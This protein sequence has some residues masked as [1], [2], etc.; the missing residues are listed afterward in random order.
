MKTKIILF[1]I[2]VTTFSAQAQL[3]NAG[4]IAF[5]G[6]NADA[7][8][9]IAFITFKDI[10]ANT[11]I[12]FC[13]SEW[14]GTSFGT[15][16]GDFTWSSGEETIPAGTIITINELSATIQPSVGTITVN[17][18]GGLSSSSDAIFAFVGTSPRTVSTMLAAISN[19]LTGFGD[20]SNS[21]LTLGSTAIVLPEGTDIAVYDEIKTGL[22]ANGYL[23]QLN[24]IS[25]WKVEDTANDDSANG[26]TPDLP[27]NTSIFELAI[28]DASAPT[29]ATVSVLTQNTIIITFSENVNTTATDITNYSFSPNITI[30]NAS[31]DVET[32][33]VT[34][35]HTGF[36]NGTAYQ[37][38]ISNIEDTSNNVLDSNYMSPN[39]FFNSLTTGLIFSEIMYNAP[40]ENSDQLEFLEIYN[41]SDETINLGGLKVKDSGNFIFEF[42]ESTVP[43]G[44]TVLLATDKESADAFYGVI[45][46]D[47]PQGISNALGNGGEN[48]QILNSQ[49]A[50]ISQVTY[51]DASP[52]A[53]SADGTGP[54]LELLNPNG[55]FNDGNNW[56]ASTNLVEISLD[57]K[58]YASPGVF[59]PVEAVN[60]SF[61]SE[62]LLVNYDDET[63]SITINLSN[64]SNNVVSVNLTLSP[65]ISNDANGLEY[66]FENQTITFPTNVTTQTITV[67]LLKNTSTNSDFYFTLELTNPSGGNLGGITQKIIYVVGKEKDVPT[68]SNVLDINHVSSY[69]VDASGS[70]EIVA[71]DPISQHLFVMNSTAKKVEILDFS[72]PLAISPIKTIDLSS[73]GIGGTSVAVKNGIIAAT[74]E[75]ENFQNGK[76]IFMDVYGTILSAIEVGVLP[77]MV[78]FTPDGTKVITANEGQPSDDYTIDPEGS[79]SI[80]D[81]SGGFSNL[82]QANVTHLN[83]NA[84][85]SQI[86]TLKASGIRIFGPNS[87][88][89]QDIEPEYITIA[90]NGLTAWV[91]LQENNAIATIDLVKNEIT[92]IHP[93]G[94]KDFNNSTNTLDTS[95]KL[96]S[97]F[98]SNWPIKGMFMPDAIAN[99][100]VNGTTYLVTANEGDTRDYKGLKEEI[101]VSAAILDPVIFPNA[102]FL[103]KE[104]NLGR[105]VISSKSGDSDND[106]D[107][108]E[109]HVFGGRSFSIWNASTGELVF[110]SANDFEKITATDPIYGVLFNASNDNN[111]YKNRSDNKGP[112]PE[113]ITIATIN[114]KTYAFITLERI[115]GVITYDITNPV[116]PSYVSYKNNREVEN[117]GGDLGPEGIIYISP[118]QSPNAKGLIVMANEI[119][120]TISVYEISNNAL[121]NQEFTQNDN[122]TVYPNPV[123]DGV[124]YFNKL[125]SVSLFDS[126]GRKI[127][128]KEN[129]LS[130]NVDVPTGIYLVK[131]KE[132]LVQKIII[133]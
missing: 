93:L 108:D 79:I 10:P 64:V 38:T 16:E 113:G 56:T 78:T 58:V 107:F 106:G 32:Y 52:W 54:S 44:E 5:V 94:L 17:N 122:F 59:V 114:D 85:D 117:L 18:A 37:L 133:K 130:L 111:N 1:F 62:T 63:A 74:V 110:D 24:T 127:L 71:H 97:I 118:T 39:L 129:T 87:S 100:T 33:S 29:V 109:L 125:D 99:Y 27:F 81:I 12:I 36:M 55:N 13:D 69:L 49:N 41:T 11:S 98:M 40:S 61:D 67:P 103:K 82:T 31:Y 57:S 96:G 7:N 73:Y 116:A 9:D 66:A 46:M 4:D 90:A 3:T 77:D 53:L 43:A 47:M 124:I 68:A 95:D 104:S 76:V 2:L 8:D 92:E 101:K 131:T 86:E 128:E 42:A 15:D 25:N 34:L 83:F 70:A 91:T 22:T 23:S 14:N 120:A 121:S 28:N 6:F 60:I 123:K 72:N 20:L 89:S 30:T 88:V 45:F 26:T 21:G 132:G 75:G 50:I 126:L 105:L 80:I 102:D 65:T 35:T 84:F 119:S 115:G 51:D 19:S 112:E 48:L